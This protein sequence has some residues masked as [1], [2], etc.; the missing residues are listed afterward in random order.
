[1]KKAKAPPTPGSEIGA[2]SDQHVARPDVGSVPLHTSSYSLAS[3]RRE[4]LI[5]IAQVVRCRYEDHWVNPLA[6]PF[7]GSHT[8][9]L[10]VPLPQLRDIK[11]PGLGS[12]VKG[13]GEYEV[14]REKDPEITLRE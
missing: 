11:E 6:M 2:A 13:G 9:S 3:D 4:Y 7:E 14:A 8:S 10:L 1:M 5:F 12:L